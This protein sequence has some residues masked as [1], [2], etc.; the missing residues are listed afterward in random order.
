M[1]GERSILIEGLRKRPEKASKIAHSRTRKDRNDTI[2]GG[3]K[4]KKKKRKKEKNWEE[5]KARE[6]LSGKKCRIDH[7]LGYIRSKE[8]EEHIFKLEEGIRTFIKSSSEV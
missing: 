7:R 8:R 5:G 1:R 3:R 4:Q 2:S 6:Q